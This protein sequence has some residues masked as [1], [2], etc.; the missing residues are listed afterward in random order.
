MG[1]K[2]HMLTVLELV[3]HNKNPLAICICECG[4]KTRTQRGALRN[5]KAKSCGCLRRKLLAEHVARIRLTPEERSRRKVL[6]AKKWQEN[7]KDKYREINRRATRKFYARHPEKAKQNCR[8]RRARLIGAMG[9]VSKNIET[10]LL[11]FQKGRCAC[12][13]KILS[14]DTHLDHITPLFKGGMHED[15]NLQLLCA[16]CNLSKGHK[17]PIKFMQERGF[18]I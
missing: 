13:R 15:G 9:A 12:C 14:I 4:N 10:R 7:N 6:S 18:L 11:E 1:D 5:G 17:D 16:K 2:F 3:K 8:N